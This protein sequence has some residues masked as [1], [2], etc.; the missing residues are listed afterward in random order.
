MPDAEIAAADPLPV[1]AFTDTAGMRWVV[2]LNVTLLRQI[3][4]RLDLDLMRLLD[5]EG[6]ILTRLASDPALLVD[7]IYL[8]CAE[9]AERLGISDETFGRRLGGDTLD[10]ATDALLE[11]VV[12]FFPSA[13]RRIGRTMLGKA[14]AARDRITS[15]IETLLASPELDDEIDRALRMPGGQSGDSPASSASTPDL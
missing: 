7:L 8:L 9:E 10:A 15:R 6:Q 11:A 3:R 4:Q 13:Q 5:D 12:D 2:A 14:R 1:R